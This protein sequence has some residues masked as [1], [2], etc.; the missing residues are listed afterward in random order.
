MV[1]TT[2]Q[3][4]AD[5]G[6]FQDDLKVQV[7]QNFQWVDVTN[8]VVTPEIV[9]QTNQFTSYTFTFDDTWGDGVRV[10]GTPAFYPNASHM[11]FTSAR[12]L[13][14]FYSGVSQQERLGT[15]LTNAKA[16]LQRANGKTF[17]DSVP[18][19]EGIDGQYPLSAYND[20]S[21]GI[22]TA[23]TV[24]DN[25]GAGEA[26]W[27]AQVETLN[28]LYTAFNASYCGGGQRRERNPAG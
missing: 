11:N 19:A 16:A 15:L 13:E 18:G 25:G 1:F 20:L 22:N 17:D 23:Q 28:A 27:K 8:M 2:G 10:I 6:S 4:F 7:R 26:A 24:Y 3:T 14:I 9:N 12:E 5:G 21:D